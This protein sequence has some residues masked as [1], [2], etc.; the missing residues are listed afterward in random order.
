MDPLSITT[1]ILA[2][3]TAAA[4]IPKALSRLRAFGEVP[5]QLYGLK[6][7]VSDLELVLR[8]ANYASKQRTLLHDPDADSLGVLLDRA[9]VHLADLVTRLER[10]APTVGGSKTGIRAIKKSVIWLR[11]EKSFQRL[12]LDINQVKTSLS[13]M[14]GVSGSQD[15]H[16][17]MVELRQVTF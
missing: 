3:A 17:I 15:L 11:E 4:Q 2:I 14:L 12:Q 9:K 16:H 13:L 7:E 5:R 1:G 10:L 8:Q 6:N